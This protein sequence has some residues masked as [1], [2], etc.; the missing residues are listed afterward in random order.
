MP[1]R[2]NSASLVWWQSQRVMLSK[3]VEFMIE[4]V[5]FIGLGRMG[6]R[7]ARRLLE[8]DLQVSVYD[9][10]PERASELGHDGA[11]IAASPREAAEHAQAV[12]TSVTDGPAVLAVLSGPD[13][14]LASAKD[15]LLFI[16]MSTIGVQESRMVDQLCSA[17]GV[18]YVRAPVLGTLDVAASGSLTALLSGPRE[19]VDAAL[20]LLEHLIARHHYMG[21]AEEGRVMKL[22]N[23]GM[24]GA[25]MA[26]FAEVLTVG[27]KAG[28]EVDQILDVVVASGMGGRATQGAANSV[29]Q[30]NFAPFLSSDL[31]LKDL[32]LLGELAALTTTA[33][34]VT[35]ATQQLF[36]AV[37]NQ[38]WGALDRA[39]VV[40]LLERMAGLSTP[41]A[42]SAL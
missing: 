22:L 39:A 13:G 5:G 4:Q 23:N 1:N 7:M 29:R 21:P 6:Q 17:A 19:A 12:I 40:L 11:R 25:I 2:Y 16:D 42:E 41:P 37:V 38:G 20:P 32:R 14:I 31:M 35:T 18:R 30:R 33:I 10:D 28:L 3:E 24:L 26:S 36:T 34:P 27:Q 8:A 15:E 9:I